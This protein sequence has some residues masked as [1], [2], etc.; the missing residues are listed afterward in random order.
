MATPG[1]A[2]KQALGGIEHRGIGGQY[3]ARAR[4]DGKKFSKTFETEAGARA[5]LDDVCAK[6]LRPNRKERFLQ[7]AS[8]TLGQALRKRLALTAGSKNSR[9][10]LYAVDRLERDFAKLCEKCIYDVD[11]LD[12]LDFIEDRSEEVAPATVNRDLCLLSHTFNLARTKL[13]CT[14]LR[15]PIGPTTRLKIP[16]GRV[17]RLSQ[18]EEAALLRQASIDELTSSVPIGAII[19]FAC[20]T[21][22]RCGEIANMHWEHVDLDRGTVYLPDT[23]NGEARSVPLWLEMRA[24]LRDLGP[25]ATG[26]VWGTREGIRSAW[27][28]VKAAAIR[29]A[30]ESGDK[31]LAGCLA[32]FRFHDLRH[33]GTS[34]L[35]ERTGWENSK[36]QAVTGHKTAAMLAR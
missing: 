28:R 12:I 3:R 16:P 26:P 6:H 1:K 33:E 18:Q 7:A 4:I 32:D 13:G 27:R 24:L 34:R 17:R 2:Q 11:E 25:K 22:M 29:K 23:K 14:N 20:E 19:R 5:W 35:I 15:N 9:N 10:D 21:A 30:T 8:L 36:I 31:T